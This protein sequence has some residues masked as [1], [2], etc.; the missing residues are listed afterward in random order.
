MDIGDRIIELLNKGLDFDETRD[1][2]CAEY[3]INHG[4]Y[5]HVFSR[6]RI[7]MENN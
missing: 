6:A 1:K 3:E 4:N 7:K 5:I 2:V